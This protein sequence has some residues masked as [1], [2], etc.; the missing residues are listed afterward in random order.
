MKRQLLSSCAALCWLLVCVCWVS[1]EPVAVSVDCSRTVPGPLNL[2]GYVNV[3]RRAP[4]PVELCERIEKEFGRPK[5]TRCWLML[6]QM[7]DYRDDSYRFN[8][9]INKG[10]AVKML[11]MHKRTEVAAVSSGVDRS[12]NGLGALATLD[13]T[14]LVL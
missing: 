4:P 13:E 7:W 9:E 6:D 1:A 12:G 14:G 10:A 5:V 11:R 3:S 2:W 8:Y